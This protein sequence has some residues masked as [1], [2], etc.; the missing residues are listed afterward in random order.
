M[1]KTTHGEV[2]IRVYANCPHCEG[3]QDI[4]NHVKEDMGED[5][6]AENLE[7]EITCMDCQKQF[8]VDSVTF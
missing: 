1:T 2:D 4:F 8:I 5:F 7:T 3:F 6:R